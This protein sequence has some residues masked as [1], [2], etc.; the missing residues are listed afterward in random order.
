MLFSISTAAALTDARML[1]QV[2]R[3]TPLFARRGETGEMLF[4]LLIFGGFIGTVCC[5][6]YVATYFVNQWKYNSHSALFYDLCGVH[7]LDRNSRSM[8]KQV[9]RHHGMAEP[10]RVFTE[11]QWLDPARLGKSFEA[12]ADKLLLLRKRLFAIRK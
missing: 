6:I 5:V 12:R 10:A 1:D 7:G 4:W 2:C 3:L 11:P 8:L 9:V